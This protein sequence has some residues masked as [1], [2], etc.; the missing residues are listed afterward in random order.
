MHKKILI[1]TTSLTQAANLNKPSLVKPSLFKLAACFLYDLLVVVAVSLM[2][3][4]IFILLIG[5]ATHGF[6]RYAL[7]LLLWFT[8]GTYFV[9]CW[10]KTGQ[11]LAMQTWRL[12]VVNQHN[13][14]LDLQ[15][16]L[17]RYVLATFSLMLLGLGFLWAIVDR[18]KRYLHDRILGLKIVYILP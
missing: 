11:T 9:W 15:M 3:V 18:D 7:Q 16:L 10:H 1:E 14:L 5:E 17:K 12:K 6:K 13:Q 2:T 8:V 4:A